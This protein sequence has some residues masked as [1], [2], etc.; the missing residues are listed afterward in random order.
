MPDSNENQV[1]QASAE[2]QFTPVATPT[3]QFTSVPTPAQPLAAAPQKSGSNAVK[4]ILII[5]AV[6]VCLGIAAAGVFGYFVY[7]VA[8]A[9]HKAADGQI[10]LGAPGGGFNADTKQ[11][12]SES[13]LGVPIYPGATQGKGALHMSIAGKT[14]VTANYLTSDSV[15]QVIAFYKD[16]IGSDAQTFTTDN[17]GSVSVTKGGDSTSVTVHQ[18][19]GQNDGKTQIVIVHTTGNSN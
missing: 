4:I 18:E 16:K 5:V 17:G 19:A 9:V 6:F 14:M 11:A 10:S 12:V 3:P 2:P 13:D 7:R 1:P 15:E 8:H